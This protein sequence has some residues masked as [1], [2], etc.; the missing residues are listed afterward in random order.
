MVWAGIKEDTIIGRF[1]VEAG[2][3]IDSQSYCELLNKYLI[4]WL[5]EQPL[6]LWRT[7]IFQQDNA[8]VPRS[9][10]TSDWLKKAG[11]NNERVMIWPPNGP[12]LNPMENLGPP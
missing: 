4:P 8:F 6:S 11:F 7:M 5:E 9:A 2:G 3:K 1:K 10:Y 12:D